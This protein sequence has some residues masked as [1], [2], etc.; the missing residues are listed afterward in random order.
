MKGRLVNFTYWLIS[1]TT[2]LGDITKK[3]KNYMM[4]FGIFLLVL[5][6]N[7]KVT[8]GSASFAGLGIGIAPPQTFPIGLALFILL[9][10]RTVAFWVSILL[11]VG[12][13][14]EKAIHIA[15]MEFDPGIYAEEQTFDNTDQLIKSE[16]NKIITKWTFLK[17]AWEIFVPNI[18]AISA[19]LHFLIEYFM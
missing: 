14:M 13:N 15:T 16:A 9:L 6:A 8:L 11:D 18:V 10:Y 1:N 4:L 5:D 3:H 17:V 12:T 19:L 2:E 7:V